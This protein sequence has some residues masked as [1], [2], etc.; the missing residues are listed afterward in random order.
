MRTMPLAAR[1][2]RETQSVM[3][4]LASVAIGTALLL[5]WASTGHAEQPTYE[6][7]GLPLTRHQVNAVHTGLVRESLAT[8]TLPGI[9][10][11]PH[12]A[13]VLTPRDPMTVGQITAKLTQA[14]Y[15]RVRFLVPAAYTVMGFRDGEWFKLTVDSATGELR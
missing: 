10:H 3:K 11:S 2:L 9:P 15:S 7:N 8:P 13:S 1:H 4:R 12:Q 5:S 6:V 14:G